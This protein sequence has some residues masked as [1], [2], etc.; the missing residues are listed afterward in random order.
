MNENSPLYTAI[1][2]PMI[3]R[4]PD[5]KQLGYMLYASP[6]D[7]I[8]GLPMFNLS[9]TSALLSVLSATIDFET[10][11]R[12]EVT[13]QCH[14]IVAQG[15]LSALQAFNVTV[16][17][18]PESPYPISPF[19]LF[20][21]ENTPTG[22]MLDKTFMVSDQDRDGILLQGRVMGNT[23]FNVTRSAKQTGVVTQHTFDIVLLPTGWLNFEGPVNVYDIVVNI[24]DTRFF[25]TAPVRIEVVNVNERPELNKTVSFAITENDAGY[26]TSV[27]LGVGKFACLVLPRCG[28]SRVPFPDGCIGSVQCHPATL[29]SAPRCTAGCGF[30]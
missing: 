22:V 29:T 30:L 24:T 7:A 19:S 12:Y 25:V 15:S 13:V 27:L 8:S 26:A 5:G 14:N 1:P 2:P 18:V 20:P 28:M 3:C 17:D 4:D 23:I 21:L 16:V 6:T 10:L 11:S 9:S